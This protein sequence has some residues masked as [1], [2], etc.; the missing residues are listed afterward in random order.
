[1]TKDFLKAFHSRQRTEVLNVNN[2]SFSIEKSLAFVPVF[3][4]KCKGA[5]IDA[6]AARLSQITIENCTNSKILVGTLIGACEIINCQGIDIV[7]QQPEGTIVVNSTGNVH[8]DFG[9]N[10]AK[11]WNII[12]FNSNGIQVDGSSIPN[13][14]ESTQLKTMWVDSKLVSFKC[15]NYGDEI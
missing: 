8:I 4:S 5:T 12:S 1:M 11:G 10:G 6:T 15:N 7:F 14:D 13:C 2:D 3:V 9:V